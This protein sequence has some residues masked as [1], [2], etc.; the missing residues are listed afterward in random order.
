MEPAP[1]RDARTTRLLVVGVA[2]L[3]LLAI[4]ALASRSG[5]GRATAS[6]PTPGYVSWAMSV[7]LVLFVLA[8][9]F[10]AWLY[11]NQQR[12]V[13]RR[14]RSY[15]ARVARS[16]VILFTIMLLGLAA[17]WLRR[18]GHLPNLA[19]FL[20]PPPG[21]HGKGG[22]H[23]NVAP[24]SPTFKWPVLWATVGILAA[25]G[26]G[27][28]RLGRRRSPADPEELGM[29][30]DDELAS[31]IDDAID[32]LE[33][34]PDARLAVIAAYARMERALG[35]SGIGRAPSE[36]PLEYLRRVLLARTANR[37]AVS[38]LT[39]LFER[40]KFSKHEI[41]APMKVDA[42]AALREIRDGLAPA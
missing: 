3:V 18:N 34:E 31:S 32:D 6:R 16:L 38:R 26:I 20:A 10:A 2:L 37:D 19:N 8:I 35:R 21:E 29:Q 4:V 30:I 33:S 22:L 25:T 28:L 11:A 42:I 39:G 27:L 7:F 9:P 14:Q 41:D 15:Q 36:T 12:H 5:F 24:Y 23:D 13:E 1:G 17:A 40:A